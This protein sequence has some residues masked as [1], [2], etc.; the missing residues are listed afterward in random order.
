MEEQRRIQERSRGFDT[1]ILNDEEIGHL[2]GFLDE[3]NVRF[4]SFQLL[5]R[6]SRDGEENS[7]FHRLCDNVFHLFETHT[8]GRKT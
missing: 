7:T 3:K 5:F 8:N 2:I 6:S 4:E 1:V